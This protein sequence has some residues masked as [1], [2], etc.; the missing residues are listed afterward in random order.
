VLGYDRNDD[1]A[2]IQLRGAFGLPVA[3]LGDSNSLGIGEPVVTVGNA[4][5][6]GDPLT[7][8]QGEVTGLGQ[9]ISAEDALTG[10]SHSLDNLIESSTNLRS[11]DSGGALINAAG[12]VV[13]LNAAATYNFR[14]DGESTPGGTG[15]AIPINDALAIADQIRSGQGTAEVHIGP[16]AILGIGVSGAG[17]EPDGITIQSLLRGG[18]A[19]QAGLRPGD[20]LMRIDGIPVNSA[21]SLTRVLDQRYPGNV[22]ELVWRDRAG[23]ERFGR[24]TL[25][26]G[27]TS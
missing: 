23:F 21:N 6:T 26:S 7:R 12:Q 14:L 11:G 4:N 27:A 1:V 18:P 2:L 8:E 22:I 20:V 5:G 25:T 3:P 17:E 13:G 16:S 10:T 9:T 24:A 19:D 15:Y